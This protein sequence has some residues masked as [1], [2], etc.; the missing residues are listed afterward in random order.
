MPIN[1][2]GENTTDIYSMEAFT[3]RYSTLFFE[4]SSIARGI[5]VARLTQGPPAMHNVFIS[6]MALHNVRL[7]L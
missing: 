7:K 6:I 2:S 4:V 5:I 1:V 3:S